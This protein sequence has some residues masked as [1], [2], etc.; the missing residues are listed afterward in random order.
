[1]TQKFYKSPIIAASLRVV[2]TL[3]LYPY[4]WTHSSSYMYNYSLITHERSMALIVILRLHVECFLG[5]YPTP[6]LLYHN[7]KVGLTIRLWIIVQ[8]CTA[9]FPPILAIA[10]CY[11]CTR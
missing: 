7:Y 8:S 2:A 3:S 5:V 11:L 6:A 1:M 9:N 4:A 10:S